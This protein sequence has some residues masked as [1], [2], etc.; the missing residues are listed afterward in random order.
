MNLYQLHSNSEKLYGWDRRTKMPRFAYNEAHNRYQ[1][2]GE[3]SPHLEEVIIKD[4]VYAYHYASKIRRGWR[5]IEAEDIIGKHPDTAYKYARDVIKKRWSDIGKPE[6]EQTILQNPNILFDY[7]YYVVEGR[8]PEAEPILIK[9]PH[10]AA[11]YAAMLLKHKFPEGTVDVSK[12]PPGTI[13]AYNELPEAPPDFRV[14]H[15]D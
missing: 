8:W 14:G 10:R 3:R 1:R 4:P 5:W 9:T 6:V 13:A 11:W 7:A 15:S 2:T 12:C